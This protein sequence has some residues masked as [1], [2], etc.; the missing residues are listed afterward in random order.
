MLGICLM[1]DE[2][3]ELIDQILETNIEGL[4]S[5]RKLA[6]LE[7]RDLEREVR[8][9]RSDYRTPFQHLDGYI[10]LAVELARRSDALGEL[11]PADLHV[12]VYYLMS[13]FSRAIYASREISTLLKSG[14]IL[15]ALVLNRTLFETEIVI[16]LLTNNAETLKDPDFQELLRRH[17]EF[18]RARDTIH[19]AET[20][21]PAEWTVYDFTEKEVQEARSIV[22]RERSSMTPQE[23]RKFKADFGWAVG[24]PGVDRTTIY[25][26]AR[27]AGLGEWYPFYKYMSNH[28]HGNHRGAVMAQVATVREQIGAPGV[29]RLGYVDPVQLMCLSLSRITAGLGSWVAGSNVILHGLNDNEEESM[30]RWELQFLWMIIS[31]AMVDRSQS[32]IGHFVEVE[33]RIEKDLDIATRPTEHPTATAAT[34]QFR[35]LRIPKQL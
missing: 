26:L 13:H 35:R 7:R 3:G 28:A 24:L 23:Y 5:A 30:I 8:R 9:L 31:K 17:D 25:D 32:V 14:R 22:E 20:R 15:G 27:A 10:H 11:A 19:A 16:S 34:A 29:A 33:R 1:S 12:P 21:V 2:A 6:R 4:T 18:Q